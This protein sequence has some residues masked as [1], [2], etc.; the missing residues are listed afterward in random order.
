MAEPCDATSAKAA[1]PDATS[2]HGG[3]HEDGTVAQGE[4]LEESAS[5][6][7][8]ETREEV[9]AIAAVRGAGHGDS[10]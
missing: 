7:V 2:A 8:L 6:K 10:G 9:E 5:A 1:E 4:Q 3:K